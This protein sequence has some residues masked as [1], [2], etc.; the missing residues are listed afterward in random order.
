M[1]QQVIKQRQLEATTSSKAEYSKV[2]QSYKTA[3]SGLAASNKGK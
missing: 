1:L 2:P 3:L